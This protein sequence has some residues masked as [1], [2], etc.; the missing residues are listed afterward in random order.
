MTKL[1]DKITKK[2]KEEKIQP[3]SKWKFLMKDYLIW[4][5]FGISVIIGGLAF[6]VIIFLLTN[7]D[8]SIYR[9]LDKSFIEYTFL[10][11]PYFWIMFLGIF[12][13]VAYYNYKHTKS[14]YKYNP[15]LAILASII[16]SFILGSTLFYAGLG[17]KIE[18]AFV[19]KFPYYKN[20]MEKRMEIWNNSGQGLLAGTIE[21]VND[22]SFIIKDLSGKKWEVNIENAVVKKVMV[23]QE[24]AMVKI[25]GRDDGD[26][27]FIAEQLRPWMG[28]GYGNR[29]A[30]R[31]KGIQMHRY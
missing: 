28:G 18:D 19:D 14:G 25:I 9:N 17:S 23:I 27:L 26:N 30:G 1:T 12:S 6:A 4:T 15:L 2:I 5:A 21:K 24:G 7:N 10:S 11:L 20:I 31:V 13:A 16:L 8:W 3:I 22:S 29:G